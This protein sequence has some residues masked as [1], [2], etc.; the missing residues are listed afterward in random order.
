MTAANPG[1]SG[2]CP[3][4]GGGAIATDFDHRSPDLTEPSIWAAYDRLRE[5]G[6]VVESSGHGGYFVLS[7]FAEVR[8]ALR[9]PEVFSSRHGFLLPAVGPARTIPIDYDPPLHTEYRRVMT[10]ALTPSRVRELQ[11]FLTEIIG[12]LV[13]TFAASGGGDVV[14]SVALPLPLAVLTEVVGFCTDT[15]SQLRELT[16]QMWTRVDELDYDD[17]RSDIRLLLEGE[18][19]RHRA[20]PVDDFVTT[21]LAAEV[22]GRPISD[23][24]AVRVLMTMA[25]AGHETTM[26]AAS[27]LI[28]LLARDPALQEELRGDPSQAPSYVEE[29][30][31]LRS[32]AQNF[33]RETT[34]DVLVDDVKVPAHAPVLLSL[35][36]ANR[37]PA[38][39][40]R[41]EVFDVARATRGHLAFGWGIHQC[42]GAALARAELRLLLEALC[43][44]P[45][46]R[47]AGEA[48]FG[49]PHG[50]AH[51]GPSSVPVRFQDS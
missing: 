17:A 39:F 37:D 24:E 47:L 43:T 32:P 9:H 44:H 50:G 7:R 19:E 8:K 49:S 48:T 22:D 35:A 34:R 31:R 3:W 6:P 23:D 14:Q 33:A 38:Q 15:V 36:A 12:D 21:L 16:E 5:S 26:N 2:G 11:P 4:T 41:P 51:W 20:E 30:L 18:M 45:P 42:L 40:P 46:I 29:M 1:P 28:W 13:G 25:I 27:S 10:Q